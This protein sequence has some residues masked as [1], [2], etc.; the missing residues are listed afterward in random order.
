MY[1]CIFIMTWADACECNCKP[2][3]YRPHYHWARKLA[4][5][6]DTVINLYL[7]DLSNDRH[8]D[9]FVIIS[10]DEWASDKQ[11]CI[12]LTLPQQKHSCS[13][14]SFRSNLWL[15]CLFRTVSQLWT[16]TFSK[17]D[18]QHWCFPKKCRNF[19]GRYLWEHL[20]KLHKMITEWLNNNITTRTWKC[21][22]RAEPEVLNFR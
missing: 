6:Y 4:F 9:S 11:S 17:K 13:P 12:L 10:I 18:L 16:A 19:Q 21:R 14:F 2:F 8:A 22:A 15:K 7:F 3:L 1:T 20:W 5:L